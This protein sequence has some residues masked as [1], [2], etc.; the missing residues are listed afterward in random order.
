MSSRA[1]TKRRVDPDIFKDFIKNKGVSIRQLGNLC[2]T[3]ERTIRRMLQDEEV[4]LNIALDLCT[5]LD[6][7]FDDLFGKDDRPRWRES[8]ES[9]VEK[10]R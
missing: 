5:Y 9:I 4:T 6:C 8:V 10:V 2:A 1:I 7:N 3:N